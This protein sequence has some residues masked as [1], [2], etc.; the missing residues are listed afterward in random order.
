MD[1]PTEP[2]AL[3]ILPRDAYTQSAVMPQY[4]G[5]LCEYC[6]SICNVQLVSAC[7]SLVS[8]ISNLSTNVTDS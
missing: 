8:K 7:N 5:L 6:L 1:E 4:I 3:H 2:H